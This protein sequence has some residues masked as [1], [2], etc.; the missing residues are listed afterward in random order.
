MKMSRTFLTKR[1]EACRSSYVYIINKISIIYFFRLYIY[2]VSW[3]S[4]LQD[5]A[6]KAKQRGPFRG[7][8]LPLCIWRNASGISTLFILLGVLVGAAFDT[9]AITLVQMFHQERNMFWACVEIVLQDK[10]NRGITTSICI[11]NSLTYQN[12]IHMCVYIIV[13]M[14]VFKAKK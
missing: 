9:D 11:K 10:D 13:Y 7:R 5:F 8:C 1:V 3:I 12:Y 4:T 6:V 2:I 14:H